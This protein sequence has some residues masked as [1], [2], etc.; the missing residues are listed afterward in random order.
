MRW[1]SAGMLAVSMASL[2]LLDAALLSVC[3]ENC[4]FP[5]SAVGVQAAFN[6]ANCG[7]SIQIQAGAVIT[8]TFTIN[9][10]CPAGNEIVVT[11]T[12]PD[13]LPDPDMRI[14]PAYLPLI[15]ILRYSS[16]L[17]VPLLALNATNPA[18]SGIKIVGVA[19]VQELAPSSY[20][21]LGIGTDYPA[22][23]DDLPDNIT[24]DRVYISSDP[25]PDV[26]F[27]D[28]IRLAT[29]AASLINSFLDNGH[30]KNE[31][32]W[33]L[34]HNSLGPHI[35]RN[36][37]FGGG[38][39]SAVFYGG[40]GGPTFTQGQPIGSNIAIESNYFYKSYKWFPGNPYFV[41]QADFPCMKNMVEFKAAANAV[42]RWNAGENSWGGC[43]A[44]QNAFTLTPRPNL[45]CHG[46]RSCDLSGGSASLSNGNQT[47]AVA[48]FTGLPILVGQGLALPTQPAPTYGTWETHTVVA[49]DNTQHVYSVDVPFTRAYASAGIPYGQVFGPWN[50]VSNIQVYGNYLKNVEEG[51]LI[52]GVDDYSLLGTANNLV[53]RN[54]VFANLSPEMKISLPP[55][56]HNN[57]IGLKLGIVEDGASNVQI[58]NNTSFTSPEADSSVQQNNTI[59][60]LTANLGTLRGL[61]FR[62][63][64]TPYG[65]Y[66]VFGNGFSSGARGI[67][68]TTDEAAA[69]LN[70]AFLGNVAASLYEPCSGARVCH[71]NFFGSPALFAKQFRNPA[72]NDFSLADGS[73]YRGA[74]YDGSNLG[75]DMD[76]VAAILALTVQP[77]S[78]SITFSWTLPPVLAQSGCNLEVSPDASLVTDT[79]PR[80]FPGTAIAPSPLAERGPARTRGWMPYLLVNALR[81]DYFKRATADRS[82]RFATISSDGVT[83]SFQVGASTPAMGDDGWSHDLSLLPATVYYYRL[84]CGGATER[85]SIRTLASQ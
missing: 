50:V 43:G 68:A 42:I 69:F 63:N 54:N 22:S 30:G 21:L 46:N 72:A 27:G 18:P 67:N 70:N 19:F 20:T 28:G 31:T 7:D 16:K 44:Q 83:R 53:I 3:S 25:N 23:P 34:S 55:V 5:L 66:G 9:K 13:W 8:G 76:Q 2:N 48:N 79:L 75:A 82:N 35:I 37:Y 62:N 6:Q 49:A 52:S 41:G 45:Q 4:N 29:K 64:L 61:S 14:T 51:F 33:M 1:R 12:M 58:D 38:M 26:M 11:T 60:L 74:G 15:P 10:S 84:M 78:N 80:T 17:N 85:G 36:N 81:P 32:H 65:D 56:S 24:L 71:G 39:S 47:V 59:L 77:A 40:D 73:P 57:N